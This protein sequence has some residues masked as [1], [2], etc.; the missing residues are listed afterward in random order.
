MIELGRR[1]ENG[2]HAIE[3]PER[4]FGRLVAM[5]LITITLSEA[6]VNAK[7]YPHVREQLMDLY[8]NSGQA[9]ERQIAN[10]KEDGVFHVASRKKKACADAFRD[11]I[12]DFI[13]Y[14]DEN[15]LD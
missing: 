6:L 9:V 4:L 2:K 14:G 12:N 3:S 13:D 7:D 10:H 11:S 5:E 1:C 8:T 15:L